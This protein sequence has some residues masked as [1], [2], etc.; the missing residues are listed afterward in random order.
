LNWVLPTTADPAA[1]EIS[2]EILMKKEDGFPFAL[3]HVL[4]FEGGYAD[5]PSDPGGA[6]NMGITRKTL[7]RWRAISPWWKLA[8]AEVRNLGK[9]EAAT[10]YRALYW[11]NAK[12]DKM[13]P[14]PALAL[15]DF[16]VNS[17][18]GRAVRVLQS[19]LGVRRDGIA[20]PITL[21]AV[22]AF[23]AARG[24]AA[25]IH[26]LSGRRLGFL[27]KLKIFAVFGK[28]WTRR[29]SATKAR[30]LSL[31]VRAPLSDKIEK[32]KPEM[33]LLN[34]YKTYIIAAVMVAIGLAQILGVA[35]PSFEG[36]TAGQLLMEGLA[37]LFLRKGLK[38]DISNA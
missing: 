22:D 17:G 18:V 4:E 1:A 35:V 11:K 21:G 9:K 33:N 37:I 34:G 24:A 25:L 36:Q 28:G 10:I 7:A 14:G 19:I 23:V 38:G 5:H 15:F 13:P 32:R 16:A 12:A 31:V 6:T 26:A 2:K 30:A 29:V 20:G 27:Q 3:A 8:K